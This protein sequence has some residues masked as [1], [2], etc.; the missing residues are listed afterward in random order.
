MALVT[1][2]D[3]RLVQSQDRVAH[4]KRWG[5]YLSE[6]QWG[7]VREDYSPHGDVW[8]YFPHDHARSRAYRW[9]EDGLGGLCDRH[10]HICFALA[11]WNEKDPILKERLFGLSNPEGNHGEDVKE[12]YY[13]LDAAP[14]SCYLKYLYKYPHAAFPYDQLVAENGRR[15]RH[16]PEYELVDTGVFRENR[17]FDVFIEYAKQ[18]VE[19][20]LIRI[21]VSNRGPEAKRLHLL[22]TIWFRNRWDWGDPYDLPQVK[23]IAGL[24]GMETLELTEFHYGQRWL[25]AEGAPTLL[26]TENETNVERLYGQKNRTPYVKDSFHR[27]LIEGERGAVNPGLTGT[28]AAAHYSAEIAPGKSS[29]LRLRLLDHKPGDTACIDFF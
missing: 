15:T 29:T 23:R 25:I 13:Y 26:F 5:P 8:G 10:Q 1:E 3:Q 14:T 9:G 22:P 11:L 27:Y 21:T 28:K 4:W 18:S 7:T 2:E 16:D 19:E 17:Y 12:Y 24:P 20:I 6:R